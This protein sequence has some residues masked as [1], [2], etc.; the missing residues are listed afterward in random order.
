R[1]TRVAD[2]APTAHRNRVSYVHAGLREW[3]AAGPLGIEQGFTVTQRPA[4]NGPVTLNLTLGGSLQA[5]QVGSE[6][7]FVGTSG[8][9]A[10][11]YGG[12]VALDAN[13]QRLPA[14]L[15]FDGRSLRIRVDD[16]SARYPILV[17]P[18]V[19]QGPKLTGSNSGPGSTFGASVA[20]SA[21]G[22]TALVGGNS[23]NG[24]TG[25]AW[26]F[27]GSGGVWPQQGGKLTGSGETAVGEFGR[28]VALSADGNTALIGG[29][30]DSVLVG[31]AW[32]FTRSGGLWTQQ[33]GK[34]LGGSE[35]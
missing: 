4:G 18:F 35:S 21:D 15:E 19:Q 27:A 14:R 30:G 25:A 12:L 23:D 34:L 3:Y 22:N 29:P 11:R 5:R 20:L 2:A 16:T 33:G 10:L 9:T 7:R 28:S 6:L 32:V 8:G 31:A 24:A 17:D 1:T 26:V 13:K